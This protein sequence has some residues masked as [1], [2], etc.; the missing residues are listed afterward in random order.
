MIILL[1]V[2]VIAVVGIHLIFVLKHVGRHAGND[3]L[4]ILMV[5][6]P[7]IL[8]IPNIILKLKILY[9]QEQ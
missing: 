4:G 5:N 3:I 6:G 9:Q 7:L 8:A 1:I 2:I